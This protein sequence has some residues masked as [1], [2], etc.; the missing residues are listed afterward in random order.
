MSPHSA[1]KYSKRLSGKVQADAHLQRLDGAMLADLAVFLTIIRRASMAKAAIELGVTTSALSHRLRKLEE[2]LQLRLF[3]RTSRSISPTEAGAQLAAK[4]EPG[5]QI[6]SDALSGLENH[7]HAP[8]GRLRINVL[9]DAARLVLGPV[10][11]AYV[12]AF[13]EMQLDINVDDRFVDLVGEGYDAGMRY[14]DRVPQDMVSVA[15]TGP[16][17]WIVVGAP[18]LIRRVGM[19]QSPDDLLKLPCVQ[20]RV[21]D[22]SSFPWELGNGPAMLRVE[23]RGAI[24]AN[25][26]E[27]QVAAALNGIGFAYCLERRVTAEIAAGSLQP[28]LADWRSEGPPFC[29]YYP[30]RRQTPPGLRQLIDMIRI[31]EGLTRLAG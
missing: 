20:T 6:V 10:L 5:F 18:D 29:I 24:I 13:P 17:Q 7:R 15:L 22:N 12:E 26:T 25:E 1:S 2:R 23:V 14:G 9:R 27:Q 30:S 28:V 11:P 31:S 19:P 8:A 21:G 4:L 16:L 3:N